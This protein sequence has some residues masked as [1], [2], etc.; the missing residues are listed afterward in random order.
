MLKNTM[1]RQVLILASAQALFQIVSVG[2]MTVG[3]LAGAAIADSP[4]WA[5]LP[6]ATMFLGTAAMMFPASMW[7]ARVGR[8]VGFLCGTLLGIAGGLV[9]AWGISNGSLALLALGTFLIGNYQAFA[10][11]YR[12]AASRFIAREITTDKFYNCMYQI[13]KCNY[14]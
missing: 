8:R 14:K 4:R 2:V 6:I 12:F 1:H 5:T 7:M 9:A 11:F 10:Q 3:G 13:R